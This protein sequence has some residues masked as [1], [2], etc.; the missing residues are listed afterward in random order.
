MARRRFWMIDN[1]LPNSPDGMS[2]KD[3]IKESFEKDKQI[4]DLGC[5]DSAEA[6]KDL[7]DMGYDNLIGI[8]IHPPEKVS[9]IN[10]IKSS[11]AQL[12]F[13]DD[14][15]EGTIFSSY[16]FP[17]L[18][19]GDQ[20]KALYEIDRISK[21]GTRGFIGPFAPQ[22]LEDTDFSKAFPDYKNPLLGFVVQ[23]NHEKKGKWILTRSFL[24]NFGVYTKPN[25]YEEMY[26]RSSFPLLSAYVLTGRA[27][28]NRFVPILRVSRN[29]KERFPFEYFITFTK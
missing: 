11:I 7:R 25:K 28:I 21:S 26:Y 22:T 13:E 4:L 12:P 24:T 15:F 6:L 8:D 1:L 5:G 20:L 2:L 27:M 16:V 9:G 18:S 3:S 10:I 23:K 14:S 29:F 19:P 17:H